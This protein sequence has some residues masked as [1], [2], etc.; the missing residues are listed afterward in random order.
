MKSLYYLGV[1]FTTLN[2]FA[3]KTVVA[4]V[5]VPFGNP[6]IL[7]DV[8][9]RQQ[10]NKKNNNQ[11][12]SN[13]SDDY[14]FYYTETKRN[15]EKN[16]ALLLK[17]TYQA[18]QLA[19]ND[20]KTKRIKTEGTIIFSIKPGKFQIKN[21]KGKA[22]E[23]VGTFYGYNCRVSKDYIFVSGYGPKFNFSA[24]RFHADLFRLIITLDDLLT[25]MLADMDRTKT[26]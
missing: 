20:T 12:K 13:A 14:W 21:Q 17:K 24:G 2:I 4:Q 11:V 5:P 6:A 9:H 15:A 3:S 16:I 18:L 10:E 26:K 1:M 7:Y 8:A 19:S 23:F 25:K 22:E